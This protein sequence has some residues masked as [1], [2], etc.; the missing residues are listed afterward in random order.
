MNWW[1]I[2][3]GFLG[4]FCTFGLFAGFAA[5]FSL[6]TDVKA[7]SI[8]GS[9]VE[10][11]LGLLLG[12]TINIAG[13]SPQPTVWP[14]KWRSIRESVLLTGLY[15]LSLLRAS[16]DLLPVLMIGSTEEIDLVSDS[17]EIKFVSTTEEIQIMNLGMLSL[18]VPYMSF[19]AFGILRISFGSL[20][21]RFWEV[22]RKIREIPSS[23]CT[24]FDDG[25]GISAR[26]VTFQG[27]GWV[28]FGKWSEDKKGMLLRQEL[29]NR[30]ERRGQWWSAEN[31]KVVDEQHVDILGLKKLKMQSISLIV[32]Y[33]YNKRL[34][35]LTTYNMPLHNHAHMTEVYQKLC[36]FLFSLI[37][38][39]PMIEKEIGRQL[40]EHVHTVMCKRQSRMLS[41]R[42]LQENFFTPLV[43]TIGTLCIDYTLHGTNAVKDTLMATIRLLRHL[44]LLEIELHHAVVLAVKQSQFSADT[45]EKKQLLQKMLLLMMDGICDSGDVNEEAGKLEID[46]EIVQGP[47][48]SSNTRYLKIGDVELKNRI[49]DGDYDVTHQTGRIEI[50]YDQLT[51]SVAWRP[52]RCAPPIDV[53]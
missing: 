7:I 51:N 34:Q 11:V 14:E 50:C 29:M 41:G 40:M 22:L 2:S 38:E 52:C 9:V 5:L 45:A 20:H 47:A 32:R 8:L 16:L 18:A 12:L 48:E 4:V 17:G 44:T 39:Y 33:L 49:I 23:N 3:V 31:M 37:P 35:S 27:V 25:E 28:D 21:K 10:L 36:S 30:S 53:V 6:V 42:D 24:I 43:T 26:F 15:I 1:S 46:L 13:V 19:F